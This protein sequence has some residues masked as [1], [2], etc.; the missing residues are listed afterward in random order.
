MLVSLHTSIT[1]CS[2]QPF[3]Q[4]YGITS[5][6]THVVYVSFL[7]VS[8]GALQFDVDSEQQIFEKLSHAKFIYCLSFC[9]KS[10]ERKS[11]K[12]TIYFFIWDTNFGFMSNKPTHYLL[13]YDDFKLA[14]GNLIAP[15]HSQSS[16]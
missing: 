3:S 10:T 16:A 9:Q 13:H 11:P 12:K 2:L 1:D 8:D 6:N 15:S 7:Y 4:D 14:Y 5:H